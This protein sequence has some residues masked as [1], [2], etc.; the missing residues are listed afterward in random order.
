MAA[1]VELFRSE[2]L[3]IR[4]H[5]AR[6][7]QRSRVC[8]VTFGSYTNDYDLDRQGFAEDF[9]LGEGIDA[10]HVVNRDNRWYQYPEMDVALAKV[11]R[12]AADY[13]RVF[14]YGSSMGGYAALRFATRIG[15][16]T[17][18]AISPQYSLDPA[19]VPFEDRWQADL[20]AI[21]FR[22]GPF[23]PAARQVIF[24]DPRLAT[25]DAHVRLFA[26]ESRVERIGIPFAGHPVGPMLTETG[27]L[28]QAIR[29]L[30][31]GDL[32]AVAVQRAVRERR[33]RSPHH[34][35]MLARRGWYRHPGARVALLGRAAALSPESHILSELAQ[36]LDL[37][38]RHDDAAPNHREAIRLVPGNVRAQ[39]SYAKHLEMVGR[40]HAAMSILKEVL[41][42]QTGSARLLVRTQQVRMWLRGHGLR[43]LDRWFGRLID[44]RRESSNYARTARWL[45]RWMR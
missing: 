18:I 35:F 44:Q 29:G 2:D 23:V 20:A 28:K 10:V 42:R 32:D 12:V 11:A 45:G 27:V 31:A 30:V 38:G 5:I 4:H 13:V 3:A 16:D 40:R 14:T 22:E 15:A 8:F 7:E 26:A 39:I 1:A 34:Y 19:V 6:A 24:Y 33:R 25:D 9:L 43:W 41:P 21:T 17:A 37:E 36:A